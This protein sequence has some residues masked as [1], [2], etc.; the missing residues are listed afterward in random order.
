[1]AAYTSA[2]ALALALTA[3]ALAQPIGGAATDVPAVYGADH[4]VPAVYGGGGG[5]GGGSARAE[6]RAENE[7]HV[8]LT[9][10]IANTNTNTLANE[11]IVL[12]DSPV[13]INIV[14]N[15]KGGGGGN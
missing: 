11:S 4:G 1:M 10:D 6:A 8:D 2:L 12:T 13:T 9:V 7:L 15:S 5:G 14:D 3:P